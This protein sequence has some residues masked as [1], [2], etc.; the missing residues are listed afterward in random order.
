MHARKGNICSLD[1]FFHSFNFC[2]KKTSRMDL[3]LNFSPRYA[4]F[5]CFKKTSDE[6]KN[7]MKKNNIICTHCVMQLNHVLKQC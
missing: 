1:F 5:P 3:V 2:D 4:N 7:S 6:R